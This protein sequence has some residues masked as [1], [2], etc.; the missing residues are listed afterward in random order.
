MNRNITI[1]H[2]ADDGAKITLDVLE[3]RVRRARTE[4][5]PGTAELRVIY[6]PTRLANALV[7]SVPVDV[8]ALTVDELISAFRTG[9]DEVTRA[10]AWNEL[11]A[12]ARA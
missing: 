2:G 5:V 4:G 9:A 10:A 11:V 6:D 8:A 12:R 1:A 7:F 3:A